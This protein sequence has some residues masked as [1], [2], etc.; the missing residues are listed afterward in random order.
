[1][2]LTKAQLISKVNEKWPAVHE[3]ATRW[4]GP[5]FT[6]PSSKPPPIS[7]PKPP[8]SNHKPSS[9]IN[10]PYAPAPKQ[11]ENKAYMA[12][13]AGHTSLERANGPIFSMRA[14]RLIRKQR[15]KEWNRWN[16]WEYRGK[17]WKC[18]FLSF[19]G[20][21]RSIFLVLQKL[22]LCVARGGPRDLL[23]EGAL[24]YGGI[25]R[26]LT[27]TSLPNIRAFSSLYL[28]YITTIIY[29][30]FYTIILARK[31]IET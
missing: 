10:R 6:P 19:S 26:D 21:I 24:S 2:A 16:I 17:R 25:A 23:F 11:I 9:Y 1:M 28:Q 27:L 20:G 31:L 29:Y 12:G 8:I 5:G 7:S 30:S 18:A 4:K 15:W 13:V 14:I 22:G 3:L